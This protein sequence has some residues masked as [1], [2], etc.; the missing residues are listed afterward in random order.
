VEDKGF[1]IEVDKHVLV[2]RVAVHALSYVKR[3]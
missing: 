3:G 2:F 1:S